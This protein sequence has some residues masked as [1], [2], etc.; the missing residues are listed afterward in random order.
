MDVGCFQLCVARRRC[1]CFAQPD[2]RRKGDRERERRRISVFFLFQKGCLVVDIF[3]RAPVVYELG[4][5]RARSGVSRTRVHG[6]IPSPPACLD[7]DALSTGFVDCWETRAP[8]A[9]HS[10]SRPPSR[11]RVPS[12]FSRHLTRPRRILL[13]FLLVVIGR[14]LSVKKLC[15]SLLPCVLRCTISPPTSVSPSHLE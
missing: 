6:A 12:F 2:E 14:N 10:L 3:G 9:S 11:P 8:P 5:G 7:V 13:V 1:F 15:H 4:V